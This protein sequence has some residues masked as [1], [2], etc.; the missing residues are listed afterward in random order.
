[1]TKGLMIAAPRSG[2]GKTTV[3]LGLL[4]ALARR[5]SNVAS[6]KCGPDYI[7]P[8][9]HTIAT[10]RTSL[11]LDSWAMGASMLDAHFTSGAQ[12]ADIVIA[13]GS[14]GLFDGVASPGATGDGASADIAA[15]YGLPVIL[16]IDTSGQSQSAGAVALGFRDYRPDVKIAGIILGNVASERHRLLAERGVERSGLPV[17][18]ALPRGGVPSI[19]ERH[20]GLVQAGEIPQILK[21]VDALADAMEQC[22]NIDAILA[23]TMPVRQP[24]Y[25]ATTPHAPG[26]RIALASD[27]AFSFTYAHMLAD[28]KAAGAE[29]FPF[30]P[31]ANE[32]PAPDA[33]ICWLPGGYPELYAG[34]LSANANFME[35]LRAFATTRPVH[36]ECGGYMVL[37]EKMI[38]ADGKAWDMAG[39]LPLATSFAKRKLHLGYRAVTLACDTPFARKDDCVRGHEFH[40]ASITEQGSAQ[41]LGVATD[42]NGTALGPVG[43]RAG[44]V[45]GTFFHLVSAHG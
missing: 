2:S 29:I 8:A 9:F 12:G 30:S 41:P 38:D 28:W 21:I 25:T 34:R 43:Q 4:R 22:L 19:P 24:E 27:V 42:A 39:L 6:F 7:D 11:N 16:V 32:A 14:M 18:G 20:L 36:G 17:F 45:T 10:G 44:N 15:R 33:D 37:G 3:T 13:E 5:G 31:L 1:M 40:Y 35:G 23:A 26:K